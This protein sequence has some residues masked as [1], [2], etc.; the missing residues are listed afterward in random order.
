[1]HD[2][3]QFEDQPAVVVGDQEPANWWNCPCGIRELLLLALP[4]IAS[5]ASWSMTSFV[6]R[7]FLFWY[8]QDA[9]AAALPAGMLFFT[10]LCF[11]IGLASYLNTFVAQYD[12]A[13]RQRQIGVVIRKGVLWGSLLIPAYLVVI[14]FAEPFF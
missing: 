1:M 4:L 10:L 12:G 7:V 5:T 11:P 9:M 13:G 3:S 14:P 8:S 6:D 2:S